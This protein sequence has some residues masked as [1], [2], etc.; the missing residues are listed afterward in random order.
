MHFIDR[1]PGWFLAFAGVVVYGVIG[2]ETWMIVAGST[3][4]LVGTMTLI[5]VAACLICASVVRLMDDATGDVV[6]VAEIEQP[7]VL[8]TPE[9]AAP[10]RRVAARP[11]RPA[12]VA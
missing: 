3:A 6:D 4:A 5:A 2:V 7:A 8:P 12:H 1:S 10:R 9:P 11:H